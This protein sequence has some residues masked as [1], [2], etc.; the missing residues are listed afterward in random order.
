[1]KMPKGCGKKFEFMEADNV[2]VGI[3]GGDG[4]CDKCKK[5]Y[6][7][8]QSNETEVKDEK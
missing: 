4:Y 2:Y 6:A 7:L 3:C 1:M 8:P 5:K